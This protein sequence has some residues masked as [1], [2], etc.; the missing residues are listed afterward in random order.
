MTT[1]G[2]S[3]DLQGARFVG[4]NLRG[5]RFAESDLSGVVM[6]GVEMAQVDIDAPWLP[7]G[8]FLRVNGVDVIAYVEA[9]LDERFPGRA[10]RRAGDPQGLREAWAALERTWDATLARA[11]AMPTGSVDVS[12]AGEWSFAQTL[13]HLVHATDVWLR[14]GVQ[15]LDQPFHPIGQIDTASKGELHVPAFA[16]EAPPYTGVLE[17]RADRV[18]M[19]RDYLATATSDQLAETRRNPHDPDY[20]ET[21]LSCLHVILEEEWEH[22]RFA[23]RDLDA[24]EAESRSASDGGSLDGES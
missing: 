1:F 20:P 19:V 2:D 5:A 11:A 13:R 12:V 21:V 17:A 18:A 3:D 16:T 15:E 6:R 24:I 8:G 7:H 9:E 4:A 14:K 22:H 10:A 23:V